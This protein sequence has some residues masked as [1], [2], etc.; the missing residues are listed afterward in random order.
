MD[1]G[2]ATNIP[3]DFLSLLL[4]ALIG[5]GVSVATVILSRRHERKS[6]IMRAGLERQ[7][8]PLHPGSVLKLSHC[9]GSRCQVDSESA[10]TAKAVVPALFVW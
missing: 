5:G 4:G 9:S 10:G 2:T 6:M 3:L 1:C 7:T 8:R